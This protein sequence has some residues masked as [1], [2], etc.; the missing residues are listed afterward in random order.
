MVA[1][2]F[3]REM[4]LTFVKNMIFSD[5]MPCSFVDGYQH[6]GSMCCSPFSTLEMRMEDKKQQI[7][8]KW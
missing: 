8:P 5:V 7:S 3:K 6:P 2:I 4:K 1:I